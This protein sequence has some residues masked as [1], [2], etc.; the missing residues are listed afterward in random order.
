MFNDR[1]VQSRPRIVLCGVDGGFIFHSLVAWRDLRSVGLTSMLLTPLCDCDMLGASTFIDESVIKKK[2]EF[3]SWEIH[4]KE[5]DEP[6]RCWGVPECN[7]EGDL[8]TSADCHLVARSWPHGE[9]R[10]SLLKRMESEAL[11][12]CF[13][14]VSYESSNSSRPP[15][16]AFFV[17]LVLAVTPVARPTTQVRM[18]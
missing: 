16:T 6:N 15:L 3:L 8:T 10:H 9:K 14:V 2:L 11:N 5:K 7:H 13:P 1:F 4:D 12:F 17:F 18:T